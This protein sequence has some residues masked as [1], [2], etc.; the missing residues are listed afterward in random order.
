MYGHL[1]KRHLVLRRIFTLTL[2]GGLVSVTAAPSEAALRVLRR[3]TNYGDY[4]LVAAHKRVED[5]RAL[6][7]KVKASPN[8]MVQV[9]WSTICSKGDSTRMRRGYSDVITPFERRVPMSFRAPD[10]CL[11]DV[12]AQM[13]G[14][15]DWIRVVLLGRL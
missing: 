7:F 15:G 3:H 12:A 13:T 8:Q 11:F 2:A 10:D 1:G 4:E 14:E 6:Y 9:S 5:P